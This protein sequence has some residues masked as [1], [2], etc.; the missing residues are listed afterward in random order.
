M[1]RT[2]PVRITNI[3]Y[4]LLVLSCIAVILLVAG[5][6][7]WHDIQ[8][9]DRHF[10]NFGNDYARQL[11]QKLTRSEM[12]VD[13]IAALG[14]TGGLKKRRQLSRY[15]REMS[16]QQPYIHMIQLYER[17]E[18]GQRRNFEKKKRAAGLTDFMIH[19]LDD[20]LNRKPAEHEPFH[21]PLVMVQP[22]GPFFTRY[23]G[24]DI[25]SDP[26]ARQAIMRAIDT[27]QSAASKPGRLMGGGYGS[28]LLKPIYSSRVVT[29]T[30]QERIAKAVGIAAV[31]LRFDKQLFPRSSLPGLAAL[32]SYRGSSDSDTVSTRELFRQEIP[33]DSAAVGWFP[34]F[35]FTTDLNFG[36]EKLHLSLSRPASWKDLRLGLIASI[37][38][39]LA[40]FGWL[41]LRLIKRP[42]DWYGSEQYQHEILF[43]EKERAE[44]TLASIGD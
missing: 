34:R 35:S 36:G 38:G 1:S 4:A 15:A 18:Q 8:E 13:G 9:A 26:L 19:S 44:V 27:G 2:K 21:F 12:V 24:Y 16:K 14:Q 17:V 30:R 3:L 39:I 22:D 7:A 41:F 33:A 31:Q 37:V 23:F 10:Q 5:A 6:V 25:Y 32:L 42:L 43:Q 11:R 20:D 29:G 40:L 28:T